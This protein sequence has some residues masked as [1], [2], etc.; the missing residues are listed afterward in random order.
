[1]TTSTNNIVTMPTS[2]NFASSDWTL[3]RTIGQT[4]SPFTGQQKTQEFA[5]TYWAASVTLPPMKRDQ[6]ALWQS[7]LVNCKGPVNSFQFGD[8]DAKTNQG[9][10]GQ[11]HLTA[12]RRVDDSSE[13][14][15]FSG[16]TLTAGTSIFGSL[17][18]GDFIH[19]TGATN[20]ENNGTHKISSITNATTV[21]TTTTFTTESNTA[22]CK[23]R[24]NVSGATGLALTTVSSDTGTIKAGDYLGVLSGNSSSHQ[25]FQLLMVTEDA[26]RSGTSVAVHT[27]PRLRKDLTDGYFVIFQNPKGLFRLET[28]EINWSADKVSRYGI[29]FTC[30]E[31][32]AASNT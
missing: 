32:I 25:P 19:V 21:I 16:T 4:V 24:Q 20:E 28:K 23:V 10:Y 15:S 3:V 14:L 1:M 2:P 30:L 22:S 18:A 17:I 5:N 31:D 11:T 26:V 7:F 13:T 29:S 27:E 8:P 6:A 9:T 12:S